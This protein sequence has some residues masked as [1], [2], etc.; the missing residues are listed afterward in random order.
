M[1][2]EHFKEMVDSGTKEWNDHKAAGWSHGI[3]VEF[4]TSDEDIGL[5]VDY[6]NKQRTDCGTWF[7]YKC[8]TCA[9]YDP[10]RPWH[11]EVETSYNF[12]EFHHVCQKLMLDHIKTTQ[13]MRSIVSMIK[14]KEYYP[15]GT[16]ASAVELI[17]DTVEQPEQYDEYR[18]LSRVSDVVGEAHKIWKGSPR[19]KRLM[20]EI[21]GDE[22]EDTHGDL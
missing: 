3:N 2:F 19:Y 13:E 6:L 21:F 11:V 8:D 7:M 5:K 4:S 14:D 16:L 1:S 9:G 17:D 18:A 10:E 15:I 20:K 12:E 22:Y